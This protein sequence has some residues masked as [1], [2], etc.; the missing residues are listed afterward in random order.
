MVLIDKM[1]SNSFR[2][3]IQRLDKPTANSLKVSYTFQD[4]A[5]LWSAEWRLI[6]LVF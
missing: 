4:A 2:V 3:N 1:R 5:L 6:G